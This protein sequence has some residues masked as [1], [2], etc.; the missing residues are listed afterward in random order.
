ML[1]GVNQRLD[2]KSLFFTTKSS[3]GTMDDPTG[4][5]MT[6]HLS[7]YAESKCRLERINISR[8]DGEEE[9]L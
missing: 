8:E 6:H 9:L 5:L 3:Y 4:A 1:E 7:R 2:Y